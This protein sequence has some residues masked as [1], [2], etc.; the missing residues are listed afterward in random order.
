M[1]SAEGVATGLS[2]S[3]EDICHTF[4]PLTGL[5]CPAHPLFI[6]RKKCVHV[7]QITSLVSNAFFP[8]SPLV[9]T[10]L[11][12][13]DV[14]GDY[15]SETPM[16]RYSNAVMASSL[17][18][19]LFVVIV[20]LSGMLTYENTA[21]RSELPSTAWPA[22]SEIVHS[23]ATPTLVMMVHPHC[24]CSR[25]SVMELATL[26]AEA[27]GRV[28]A[29]VVFVKPRDL[30]AEWEKTDLWNTAATIPGVSVTVDDDGV[31]AQLFDSHTSGQVMLYDTEGRLIFSGGITAA[32]GH[33]GD[34]DGRRAIASLL[35]KG[36]SEI[37][38]TPVFGCSLINEGSS[39]EIK[40]SCDAS[41]NN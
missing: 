31:E 21:G 18:A 16:K 36:K 30:P 37:R 40:D 19:W 10:G 20:G 39:E 33:Y 15:P 25:S 12:T 29:H 7:S 23:A 4:V 6:P 22:K 1:N 5:M 14:I 17:F 38:K 32:R 34:S 28:N 2:R 24:P 41:D 13:A 35:T 3:N 8:C 9:R 26:M 11:T 27:Q